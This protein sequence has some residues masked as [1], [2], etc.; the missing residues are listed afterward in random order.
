MTAE[1]NPEIY[2]WWMS[3]W[4]CIGALWGFCQ[5]QV[6]QI[7]LYSLVPPQKKRT[8]GCDRLYTGT[9]WM[10]SRENGLSWKSTV[11]FSHSFRLSVLVT[12]AL[13]W[14]SSHTPPTP[15]LT[16]HFTCGWKGQS[17]AATT[18]K[19]PLPVQSNKAGLSSCNWLDLSFYT[20]LVFSNETGEW[21]VPTGESP[22]SP[23]T[24][25]DLNNRPV[26]FSHRAGMKE[27]AHFQRFSSFPPHTVSHFSPQ[28]CDSR[29]PDQAPGDSDSFDLDEK[30][31]VIVASSW[32]RPAVKV[33]PLH[34]W[35]FIMAVMQ[36]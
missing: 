28:P 1:E 25:V 14:F 18:P 27:K 26:T 6:E 21:E 3:V 20:Y 2:S 9:H 36:L 34:L 5:V 4:V 33:I 13:R 22:A 30:V 35:W 7:T 11:F 10:G 12:P 31:G 15:P 16:E 19:M 17:C 8:R 24:S 29:V 32:T 23:N